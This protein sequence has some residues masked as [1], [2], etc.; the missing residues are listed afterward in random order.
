MRVGPLFLLLVCV[1]LSRG[2]IELLYF[3][4]TTR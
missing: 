3:L 2:G 1:E 4:A